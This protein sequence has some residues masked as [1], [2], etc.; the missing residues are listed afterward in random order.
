MEQG[1]NACYIPKTGSGEIVIPDEE[2]EETFWC[3][4]CRKYRPIKDWYLNT[5]RST[6]RSSYCKL[7]HNA[8]CNER[9][10]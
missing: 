6:G 1:H 10:G 9:R 8:E 5:A 7:C 2:P 3:P 4:R